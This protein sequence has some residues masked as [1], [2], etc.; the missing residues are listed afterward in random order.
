MDLD[1]TDLDN[2]DHKLVV[3]LSLARFFEDAERRYSS[4]RG[5]IAGL[6]G[7]R[8]PKRATVGDTTNAGLRTTLPQVADL[9]RLASATFSLS[10]LA[11]R[12]GSPIS[13]CIKEKVT[14]SRS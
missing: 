13:L 9:R 8:K 7:H 12:Q 5:G 11:I 6:L 1:Y 14:W 10:C 4:L 2:D 3:V